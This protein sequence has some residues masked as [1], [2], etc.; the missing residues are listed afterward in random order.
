MWL[1][2]HG[3]VRRDPRY[4]QYMLEVQKLLST[5]SNRHFV[6]S[7]GEAVLREACERLGYDVLPAPTPGDVAALMH[8]VNEMRL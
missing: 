1:P 4:R 6:N 2:Y 8:M 5:L 7:G 3:G